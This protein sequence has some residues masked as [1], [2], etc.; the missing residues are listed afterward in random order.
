MLGV[1]G[2]SILVFDIHHGICML[3]LPVLCIQKSLF[4]HVHLTHHTTLNTEQFKDSWIE[5]QACLVCQV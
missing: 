4:I 5:T 3:P 2:N 1:M